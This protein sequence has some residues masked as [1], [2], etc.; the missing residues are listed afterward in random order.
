MGL[1]YRIMQLR[2]LARPPLL[3]AAMWSHIRAALRPEEVALFERFGGGDRWHSYRVFA[4]LQAAGHAQ[5][6]LL[7]A[8]LLHDVGKTRLRLTVWERS[9]IVLANKL[10][11]A[12]T[13]VW[14]QGDARGWR[15]PFVVKARHPAWGAEM[16]QAAGSRPLTVTLIRRHQDPLPETAVDPV[17]RLLRLLQWADDQN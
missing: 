1:A 7:A 10:V 16:A 15:R 4:M 12:Q 13:A 5:P 14:G 2:Q 9:L 3:T 8:A 6:D 11:P 17:D